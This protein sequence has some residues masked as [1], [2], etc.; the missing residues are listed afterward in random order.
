[1]GILKR[2]PALFFGLG[3]MV[4]FLTLWFV[5][6]PLIDALEF[7]YYDAMMK[8][9]GQPESPSNIVM[10]DIDD[11]SIEKLGRWPWSRAMIANGIDRINAGE[12]KVIGL[13]LLLT[14]PETS[15]GLE[16]LTMIE[17]M[18]SGDLGAEI[19]P[20]GDRLLTAIKDAKARL[21]NDKKLTEAL[22]HSGNVILPFFFREAAVARDR[23]DKPDDAVVAASIQNIRSEAGVIVPQ[24]D[25]I[26]LPIPAF[27]DA[28]AGVGH[29]NLAYDMDGTVRKER[30]IYEYSGLYFPSYTLR[31][32]TYYL[33]LDLEDVQANLGVAVHLGSLVEI[34][35]SFYSELLVSFKGPRGSFK[36][37]S[38]F[39]VINDKIPSSVF[40]DK[41][42]LVSP[43][44]AGIMNP[45]STSTD[46]TMPVGE[47]TAQ[48]I[49]AVLN[50]QFV[51]KPPWTDLVEMLLIV[52]LGIVTAFLLPRLKA[53]IA[54]VV[55]MS[56]LLVF[57]FGSVYLFVSKGMWVPSVYP[58]LELVIGYIGVVSLSYFA[59]ETSKEKVEGESAETNRM[60]GLSFQ[61]QGM[62]D[63]A[64]DKF[65]RVPVGDAMKDI[66]YNLG[67]DYERKRQFNKAAAVYE[68]IEDEDDRFKDVSE[69]KKK[70]MQ[71]SETMVFGDSFLS[72]SGETDML[73][74]GSEVKPTL[75][76]YEVERQLGK[77]AMGV[78]YLGKDPR[79]N[80]TT[81][82]KTFRF[83]DDFDEDEI[84]DLKE[85]FFREAESA[86]TL[87]HPNIV[88]IYDAGDEQD[89]AYIAMEYLEGEDLQKYIR[90]DSLLP[91]RKVIDYVAD[92]ADGL[93]YA[94]KRGIVHRD[95]KPANI[96]LLKNGTVKITDFGIA[97]ITATSKTQTG[98]VKGTPYYMSPEQ[99]SGVKV[100]GRSDIFSLGVMLFQLLTGTL[101]F[102]ADNPAALMN[103]I[104]NVPHPDPRKT[105]PK[106]VKPL[107]LILNKALAKDR[108]KR[109]Q[110]G[111]QMCSHLR[112]T[113]RK[114]DEVLA[115]RK[116][117]ADVTRS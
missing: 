67:L 94:H 15:E 8:L 38:F 65:R 7:K 51:Q 112:Q 74:T 75:G 69:R 63:M 77:G 116:K 40:E 37:Y 17:E 81:A 12:P 104:M 95:I 114:I 79:I 80:R 23:G 85:K 42:V 96:M 18:L 100:D 49:W 5:R 53:L 61:S 57:L 44:A 109:Y 89:L 14:E 33:N 90:K 103:K 73:D 20:P 86:G 2:Y 24:G 76:R 84:G 6:L 55:F 68:Y 58:L 9:R 28:A 111:A 66:L 105:N 78:V 56:L 4:L 98:V 41:L 47:F 59:T 21:D 93:D 48:T 22:A 52:V 70:L 45:L 10:V 83:T 31:L 35:T 113:G 27:F 3:I 13:N 107:V 36:R 108:D 16:E 32:A 106:I 34:P 91:M 62:L 19:G 26:V 72:G 54:G 29:F 117:G 60:L 115:G 25:D 88:T 101:P 110:A 43:S 97:R 82:I 46:P 87:S 64:F 39:D 92:I 71:A 1:M 50:K 30:L 99:F 11:A 102:Y